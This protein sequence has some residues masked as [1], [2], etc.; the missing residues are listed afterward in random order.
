M[1]FSNA[2]E[3]KVFSMCEQKHCGLK[4]L[5]V[6]QGRWKSFALKMLLLKYFLLLYMGMSMKICNHSIL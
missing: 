5:I 1:N 3:N 6:D 4:T 2:A